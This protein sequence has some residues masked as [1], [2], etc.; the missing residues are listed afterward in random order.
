[1]ATF[2]SGYS[3]Q[4]RLRLEVTQKSQDINKNTSQVDWA[5][6]LENGNRY[7]QQY[8]TQ[9]TVSLAG[10]TA[11]NSNIQRSISGANT[12]TLVERG[13]K[14]IYHNADGTRNFAVSAVF[15][16]A[17]KDRYSPLTALTINS[18]MNLTTI[19]RASKPT[20]SSGSVN[21][22]SSVT[23]NTNRQ[24]NSFTHTVRAVLGSKSI[25]I[26][27][28]V[29]TSTQW[30]VPVDWMSLIPNASSA[31]IAI[32]VDTF[33]GSNKLGTASTNLTAKVSSSYSADIGTINV[34]EADETVKEK[35]NSSVYVQGQSRL[36][37][38]FGAT[39]KYGAVIRTSSVT[40]EGKSYPSHH[41][42]TDVIKGSGVRDVICRVTDSR[43]FTTEKRTTVKVEPYSPPKINEFNAYRANPNGSYNKQGTYARANY[44]AE[45]SSL[46]G[47]NLISYQLSYKPRNSETWQTVSISQTNYISDSYRVVPNVSLKNSYEFKLIVED[48]FSRAEASSSFGT[49]ENSVYFREGGKG[50]AF[51]KYAEKENTIESAWDIDV[52][53]LLIGKQDNDSFYSIID[54]K[55]S[56][57]DFQTVGK[58]THNQKEFADKNYVDSKTANIPKIVTGQIKISNVGSRRVENQ[59]I[60][61]TGFS[62]PPK[63]YVTNLSGA[64]NLYPLSVYYVN[65]DNATIYAYNG[66]SSTVSIDVAWV[67]IGN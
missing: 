3:N 27:Q 17:T 60:T 15:E 52:K 29:A 37:V 58:L 2:Y 46:A 42:T 7:F 40:V 30:T 22:G 12:T 61:Y 57:I 59:K 35:L 1:M 20:L 43:G 33:S 8:G 50:I 24:V 67:A 62:S 5:L 10:E 26:A 19:P 41:I 44:K 53:G 14:T 48:Y 45:I 18:S 32:Y 63:V 38:R 65:R 21:F 66:H 31:T 55:G 23:I 4:Y 49:G 34:S 28:N 64:P 54:N 39:G 56:G 51:G 36:E 16:T 9:V 11:H 6:Y 25:T 47:K 13:T